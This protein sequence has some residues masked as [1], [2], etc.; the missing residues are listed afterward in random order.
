MKMR[1]GLAALLVVALLL[2]CTTNSYALRVGTMTA[3]TM[4]LA[5][6]W[7]FM[8]GMVG[9]PSFATA[10]FFGFG[11][12]ASAILQMKGVPMALAW[13]AG[14]AS[15]AVLAG[16]LGAALLH[17]RGHYFA[18]ATLVVAEV[19]RELTNSFEGLTGGGIGLNLRL[20]TWSIIDSARLYY[21]CMVAVAALAVVV[22][23]MV[24]NS[25]TGVAFRCIR[26]NEMAADMIGVNAA[27]YKRVA[28]AL[29]AVF[30]GMAGGVYASWIKYLEPPDAFDL[31][32]SIKPIAIVLLGGAGTIVGPIVG[33]FAWM[34]FEEIVWRNFLTVH[35]AAL[36]T[37]IVL[38]V[39]FLPN[40]I[41][42]LWRKKR[43]V[44]RR[45]APQAPARGARGAG[46]AT[47]EAS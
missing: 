12:Y 19:L 37:L 18:I 31:F 45:S 4:I 27:H 40:G 23:I 47:E 30:V 14:G 29:S 41:V 42:S 43:V 35:A 44:A 10:A 15:A 21:V 38:V 6:S 8:G 20:D 2:A 25:K 33:S 7:N 13:V 36:G 39:L 32:I 1:L 11:A 16:L 24:A 9:Y 28:F 17:V 22:Q 5:V 3:L 26:Q 46:P 34:A